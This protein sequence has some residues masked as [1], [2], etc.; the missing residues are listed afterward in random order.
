MIF[1]NV[2]PKDI[3]T[4]RALSRFLVA[5]YRS[6]ICMDFMITS[7]TVGQASDCPNSSESTPNNIGKI[8]H[9]NEP[10]SIQLIK[11]QEDN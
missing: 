1:L 3:R 9:M 10:T 5:W 11:Q 6:L 4:V 7:R 8:Q 2:P